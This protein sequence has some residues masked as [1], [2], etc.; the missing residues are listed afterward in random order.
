[1]MDGMVGY[2]QCPMHSKAK[3]I[4]SGMVAYT[5]QNGANSLVKHP[6]HG[7]CHSSTSSIT[8][9]ISRANLPRKISVHE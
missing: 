3:R 9:Q 2:N 1:M 7:I 6:C 8:P 5:L 4:G